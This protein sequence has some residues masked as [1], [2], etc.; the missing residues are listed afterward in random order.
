MLYTTA[1]RSSQVCFFI[2]SIGLIELLEHICTKPS[3]LFL[4]T[5]IIKQTIEEDP[6]SLSAPSKR[7]P[8][9]N[10][11]DVLMSAEPLE[12]ERDSYT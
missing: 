4:R 5:S 7:Q 1:S 11:H 12:H 9:L 6:F 10:P 2:S 3:Y 8:F